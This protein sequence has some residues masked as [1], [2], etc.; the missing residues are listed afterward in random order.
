MLE[1]SGVMFVLKVW[2]VGSHVTLKV[3]DKRVPL[4][5]MSVQT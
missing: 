2:G 5:E 4:V 3:R 1:A